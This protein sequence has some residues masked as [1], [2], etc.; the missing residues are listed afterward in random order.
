[1]SCLIHTAC[2]VDKQIYNVPCSFS[3][4][5]NQYVRNKITTCVNAENSC[6]CCAYNIADCLIMKSSLY[7]PTIQP[8]IL[9]NDN[10]CSKSRCQSK[11]NTRH[12]Y[13][14]EN[15]NNDIVCID[16]D[17]QYCCTENRADCCYTNK[18]PVYIA[19]G[20]TF[21]VIFMYILYRSIINDTN[22]IL[23]E[24]NGPT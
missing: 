19:F 3:I 12:C 7:T 15:I 21:V 20:S 14:Y 5:F 9:I 4:G 22:K 8:T 13:W 6:D 17:K 16:N 10:Q 24:K 1:M 2:P 23:P 11:Y 18:M